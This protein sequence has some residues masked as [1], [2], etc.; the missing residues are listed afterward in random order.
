[1]AVFL[2]VSVCIKSVTYGPLYIYIHCQRM[3]FEDIPQATAAKP[4]FY[5]L[6]PVACSGFQLMSSNEIPW[7][8][9]NFHMDCSLIFPE[10]VAHILCFKEDCWAYWGQ[11]FCNSVLAWQGSVCLCKSMMNFEA[12]R[13]KFS[14]LPWLLGDREQFPDFPEQ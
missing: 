10:F 6:W 11:L 13:S 8:S 14:D 5:G 2:W 3:H 9:L 12:T 4:R 7:L 1:M